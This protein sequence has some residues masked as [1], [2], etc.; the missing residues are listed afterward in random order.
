MDLLGVCLPIGVD[1]QVT[2]KGLVSF[3]INLLLI[4][5]CL[6]RALKSNLGFIVWGFFFPTIFV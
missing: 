4:T 2:A 6:Q 1:A 3:L 5:I